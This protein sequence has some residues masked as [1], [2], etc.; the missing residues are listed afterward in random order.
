M[1]PEMNL[2]LGNW[3][4]LK[5]SLTEWS[6]DNSLIQ[7]AEWFNKDYSKE[8]FLLGIG[9]NLVGFVKAS[10]TILGILVLSTKV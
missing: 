6:L 3:P 1:S 9:V 2:L 5:W 8:D 7:F 4:W 10:A